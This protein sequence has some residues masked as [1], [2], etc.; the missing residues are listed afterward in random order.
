[1]PEF[2]HSVRAW[3]RGSY[4]STITDEQHISYNSL[5]ESS[6]EK[7]RVRFVIMEGILNLLKLSV[8]AGLLA[9]TS[10]IQSTTHILY[11]DG[12]AVYI[13]SDSKRI[14]ADRAV[15]TACKVA[16]GNGAL[17]TISGRTFKEA[18]AQQPSTGNVAF[19][20]EIRPYAEEILEKNEPIEDKIKELKETSFRTLSAAWRADYRTGLS[21]IREYNVS[22]ILI[23]FVKDVP[24]ITHFSVRINDWQKGPEPPED[25]AKEQPMNKFY[26]YL[27]DGGD[28]DPAHKEFSR[29]VAPGKERD[30]PEEFIKAFLN[31]ES[32]TKFEDVGP[33]FSI[34]KMTPQSIILSTVPEDSTFCPQPG[35]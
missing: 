27:E 21:H 24:L 12:K 1:M 34:Y 30:N 14:Y 35:S 29:P 23:R 11:Y 22:M 19:V 3:G 13:G 8:F 2:E 31:R 7:C 9:H 32:Q 33:P 6:C 25:E 10:F 4:K 18:S 5:I 16:T 20:L 15:T 17:V 28:N 26:P